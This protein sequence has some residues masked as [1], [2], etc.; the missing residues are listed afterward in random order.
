MIREKHTEKGLIPEKHAEKRVI[1]EKHAEKRVIP[2]GSRE[3]APERLQKSG[4]T[5][6]MKD[7]RSLLRL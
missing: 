2:D 1:P 5:V 4:Q 6:R 7:F 3:R